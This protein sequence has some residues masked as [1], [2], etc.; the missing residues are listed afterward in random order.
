MATAT[1]ELVNP[2]SK[3]GFKRRPTYNEIIGLINENETITGQLPDRTATLYKASPEGSFFDG[4][5]ALELMKEQQNRISQRQLQ[6][7]LLKQNTAL[8]GLTYNLE[9]LRQSSSSSSSSSTP[10]ATGEDRGTLSLGLQTDLQRREAQLRDRQQQTGE[11]HRSLLSR[12]TT[13]VIDGL[14]SSLSR[15][16]S[17]IFPR[18]GQDTPSDVARIF[19]EDISPRLGQPQPQQ[20]E[21]FIIGSE[22]EGEML[23]AREGNI[24]RGEKPDMDKKQELIYFSLQAKVPDADVDDEL[25]VAFK[26][27]DK[28]KN[29]KSN[30]LVRNKTNR[31]EVFRTMAETGYI[32]QP[33]FNQYLEL[34]AQ[35]K[36]A[37]GQ[38]NKE[39]IR[40]QMGRLYIDNIYNEFIA[41][42]SVRK[43]AE[44][45]AMAR[46]PQREADRGARSSTG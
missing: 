22:S 9:R 16:S 31:D 25:N 41:P 7:L 42:I 32:K 8:Q 4:T 40:N 43:G 46:K 23:T 11:E 3:Y 35:E 5:D 17:R 38:E 27:L 33:I 28:F 20:A 36:Q 15:Q 1:L 45:K 10:I 19:E 44:T 13:P 26:V 21:T 39:K 30:E 29:I 2:Y 14:F 6:E 34:V 37:K 18:T 12:A 24:R